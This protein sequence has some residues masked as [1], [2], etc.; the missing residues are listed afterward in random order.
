MVLGERPTTAQIAHYP[1]EM[2]FEAVAGQEA[3]A[4]CRVVEDV[5]M[6]DAH[7][8]NPIKT[9]RGLVPINGVILHP[10]DWLLELL[11]PRLGGTAI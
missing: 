9:P 10:D 11:E 7:A 6:F 1:G 4:F 8:G 3:T 5:A 2:G